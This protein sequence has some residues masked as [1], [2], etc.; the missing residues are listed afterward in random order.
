MNGHVYAS[1]MLRPLKCLHA[2]FL[3][4]R[5]P[6]TSQLTVIT[7][8]GSCHSKTPCPMIKYHICNHNIII[9]LIRYANF[10]SFGM[11]NYSNEWF[12]LPVGR[13]DAS[14][15]LTGPF[16]LFPLHRILGGLTEIRAQKGCEKSHRCNGHYH[17]QTSLTIPTNSKSFIN[18]RQQ[19]LSNIFEDVF[20][21]GV[22]TY[23]FHYKQLHMEDIWP[24]WSSQR[25]ILSLT[26]LPYNV[27]YCC[28]NIRWFGW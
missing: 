8:I 6:R 9:L 14:K 22:L 28:R 23:V 3:S 1:L 20:N 5:S 18:S 10:K 26:P 25:L 21:A 17:G 2:Q 15:F 7:V 12:D 16:K 27:K 13:S 4:T 11:K 19:N 24:D